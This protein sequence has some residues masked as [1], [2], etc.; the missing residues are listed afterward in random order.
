MLGMNGRRGLWFWEGSMP[1]CRG[2]PEQ[3]SR[4]GWWW[5]STIIEAEV[6][7]ERDFP[8]GKLEKGITF[9]M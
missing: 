1:Q 6:G 3:E 5:A 7:G 9:E 2:T 4:S 8:G